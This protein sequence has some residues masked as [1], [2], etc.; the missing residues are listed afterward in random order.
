MKLLGIEASRGIAAVLVLLL[1]ATNMLA[2]PRNPGHV[3]FGG[4]FLFGRAGVD[5][6]FVLSGFIIAHIHAGDLGRPQGFGLF[7]RKRLLRIYPVYWAV[8]A[9]YGALFFFSPTRERFEQDPWHIL[10]SLLLLPDH[11]PYPIVAVAWSLQH[12]MLFYALFSF[13]ILNRRF[14]TAALAAW[15]ATILFN[16]GWTMATGQPFFPGVWGDLVF[17]VFNIEFL[18][19]M[20]AAWAFRGGNAPRPALVATIGATIFL[21]NGMAESFLPAVMQEWP[22]RHLAYA[23]GSALAIYGLATL[24]RQRHARGQPE[25]QGRVAGPLVAVGGASYSL[26]LL[27]VLVVLVAAELLKRTRP[28]LDVPLEISYLFVVGG[29][30]IFAVVFS[31]L[32]ERPLMRAGNRIFVAERAR[33][34]QPTQPDLQLGGSRADR[35]AGSDA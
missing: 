4:L 24:D 18:F 25:G 9:L 15:F 3:A 7:W 28:F 33:H 23:L 32:V 17:R 27:H 1:H 13:L 5:F 22:P 12:E 8:T 29:T 21:A 14:G 6:F 35:G 11:Y 19:G 30:V 2:D 34:D 16:M 31:R 10:S 26:Y 20:A